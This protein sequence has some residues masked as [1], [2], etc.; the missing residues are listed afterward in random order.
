MQHLEADGR[1][2]RCG[3]LCRSAASRLSGSQRGAE[4]SK[5][6]PGGFPTR[7]LLG[8]ERPLWNLETAKHLQITTCFLVLH[9]T[10]YENLSANGLERFSGEI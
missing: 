6:E 3:F 10:L 5:S 7:D 8:G 1:G 4:R 2:E 9:T